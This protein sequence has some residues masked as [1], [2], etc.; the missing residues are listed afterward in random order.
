MLNK[1]SNSDSFPTFEPLQP[2]SIPQMFQKARET[3]NLESTSIIFL[4]LKWWKPLLVIS[5]VAAL[6][7]LIFSGPYFIPPKYC[8]SVVFFPAASNSVSK[9][10]IESSTSG[11]QDILAFGAEEQAEQILQILNSDGIR[12]IILEKYDLMNHYRIDQN[13]EY[14]KSKLYKEFSNNIT[15]S[16]T[17]YMSVRIDVLDEDPKMAAAIANDIVVLLDTMKGKIQ[18]A[19]VGSALVILEQAYADMLNLI[20]AKEDSLTELR[21]QGVMNYADQSAIWNA[22]YADAFSTYT[23]EKASLPILS[24]YLSENDTTIINTKA[25]IEGAHAR[26]EKLQLHLDRLASLGGAS[27]SLNDQLSLD[28]K[29]L[30]ILKEKLSRLKIDATQSLSQSFIVNNA[31]QSEKKAYPTRWLIILIST[32]ASLCF[33]VTVLLVRERLKEINY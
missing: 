17:E 15:F 2:N 6:S 24:K 11:N 9:A 14:P 7:S 31:E 29:E 26:I 1:F 27:V 21:K 22:E 28:R 32:I 13:V 8:S 25:R 33:G 19:R 5:L 23:N 16:R 30:A 20:K 3:V 4:L 18:K 12:D 10:I